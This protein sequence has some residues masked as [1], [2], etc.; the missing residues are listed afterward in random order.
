LLDII[1]FVPYNLFKLFLVHKISIY[2]YIYGNRKKK[3]KKEKERNSEL[4][5]LGGFWPASARPRGHAAHSARQR[6][7]RRGDGAGTAP[8][9]GPTCQRE[10]RRM[11]LGGG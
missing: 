5:G 9:C 4:T 10:G 8:W 3:W 7:K 6:G 2:E 11:A 1:I